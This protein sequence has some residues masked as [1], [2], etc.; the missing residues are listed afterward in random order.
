MHKNPFE[1]QTLDHLE[2]LAESLLYN[3][4]REQILLKL[5]IKSY[6][7]KSVQKTLQLEFKDRYFDL[8]HYKCKHIVLAFGCVSPK[9][10]L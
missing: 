7:E 3:F 2:K 10:A 4:H 5:K 8:H 9:T 6:C 1:L